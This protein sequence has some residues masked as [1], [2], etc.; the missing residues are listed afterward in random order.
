MNTGSPHC[1]VSAVV[2][3]WSLIVIYENP[4]ERVRAVN[5]YDG[6]DWFRGSQVILNPAGF[7]VPNANID[8][9]IAVFTLEGDPAN[10][11]AMNGVNEGLRYNNNPLDDG[12]NVAGSDPTVQQF[13]GTINSQGLQTSY[14]IDVDQYNISA[15]LQP[16]QTSGVTTYSSGEDLVLLMAQIVSAT[17][18]PGVDLG[19]TKTHSGNFVGGSTAQYTLTVSNS[20]AA[21]IEREDN[22]VT[23]RDTLPAGL[24]YRLCRRH[25]LD[26]RRRGPAGDL[27]PRGA[28]QCR[29]LVPADHAHRECPRD[30][31]RDSEQHRDG[32]HAQLRTECAE[33]HRDRP[34][35]RGVPESVHVHQD[36]VGSQRRRGQPGRYAALHHHADRIRGV[37]CAGCLG[38]GSHSRERELRRIRGHTRGVEQRVLASAQR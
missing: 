14:G 29:S 36:G 25:R 21:L 10:S 6:L 1:D 27:H 19:I 20:S 15:F 16:G 37:R 17:S 28:A 24:T 8:G 38:Y 33:Q 26:L 7:R 13:D 34:G 35:Q 2:S 31:A 4:N 5:L 22:T 11:G 9:R 32:E 23:V 18:D 3:G 30:R 12:I